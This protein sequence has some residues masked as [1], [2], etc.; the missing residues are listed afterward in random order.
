MK[1]IFH[2]KP[3]LELPSIQNTTHTEN[4]KYIFSDMEKF[5]ALNYYYSSIA[6]VNEKDSNQAI[7]NYVK[8]CLM[9]YLYFR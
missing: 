5:N 1:D 8:K 3:T 6:N 9:L 4:T 7:I 2:I